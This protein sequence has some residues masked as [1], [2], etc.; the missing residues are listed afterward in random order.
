M[1]KIRIYLCLL[2]FVFLS[3]LLLYFSVFCFALP[4][5]CMGKLRY[6]T[7]HRATPTY[8]NWKKWT[9][10]ENGNW[11]SKRRTTHSFHLC[12]RDCIC[13]ALNNNINKEKEG[14]D[15]R[16]RNEN[17]VQKITELCA[18][19]VLFLFTNNKREKHTTRCQYVNFFLH[20]SSIEIV[21][22]FR[23]TSGK[24][25]QFQIKLQFATLYNFSLEKI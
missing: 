22:I 15:K 1:C 17:E 11:E 16:I 23:K 6:C 2:A 12:V 13:E 4:T 24:K 20:F 3:A 19:C 25:T 5:K 8:I 7:C 14:N 10:N 9:K 21:E 18:I